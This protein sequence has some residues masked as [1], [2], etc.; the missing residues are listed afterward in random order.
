[1]QR[2]P[3]KYLHDMLDSCQFLLEFVGTR[4]RE[5]LHTD[6]AFRSAVERELQIIGEALIALAKASPKLAEQI[7][8]HARIIRFRYIL[9]HGYD[10][11]DYDILWSVLDDKLPV[12]Q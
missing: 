3:R 12:L 6:R 11:V 4:K 10:K 7:S 8:E 2:D 5:D 9:V 1:M